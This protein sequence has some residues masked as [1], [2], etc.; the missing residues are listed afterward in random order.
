MKKK[1]ILP[2]LVLLLLAPWPVAYAYDDTAAGAEAIKIEVAE[3][4]VAPNWHAYGNAIGGV[5]PGDLFYVDTTNNTADLLVTLHMTNTDELVHYYRYLTLNVGVYVQTGDDQ[6]EKATMGNG[7][8]IPETY[9][10]MLNGKVSLMLPGYANY[11]ITID[12][13]CFNCFRASADGSGSS[14]KFYLTAGQA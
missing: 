9:L 6:W 4:S 2:L 1:L 12:N 11:K 13:G 14:P 8:P 3:A 10:T 7:E 5:N